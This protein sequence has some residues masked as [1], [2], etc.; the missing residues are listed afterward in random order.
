MVSGHVCS[1]RIAGIPT[2]YRGM[3]QSADRL[4]LISR[5]KSPRGKLGQ[6][7]EPP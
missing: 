3:G 1:H 6:L 7:G 2:G 4:L 5:A